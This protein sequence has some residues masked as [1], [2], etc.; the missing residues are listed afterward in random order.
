MFGDS[1]TEDNL[2]GHSVD[3]T[4]PSIISTDGSLK[5]SENFQSVN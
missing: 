3:L 5:P 2:Q 1:F 4:S